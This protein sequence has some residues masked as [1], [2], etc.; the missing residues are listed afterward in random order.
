MVAKAM[1]NAH[2]ALAVILVVVVAAMEVRL[3]VL[4][5]SPLLAPHWSM[6]DMMSPS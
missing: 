4:G 6:L 5:W 1:G 3:R 2:V